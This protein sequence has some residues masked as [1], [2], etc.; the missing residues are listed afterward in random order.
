MH[1]AC[2]AR[3]MRRHSCNVRNSALARVGRA[4]ARAAAGRHYQAHVRSHFCANLGVAGGLLLLQSVGAG[5]FTVDRLL[6][7]TK[8]G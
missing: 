6:Q 4:D 1:S 3:C 2:D 7:K 5:S 8:G